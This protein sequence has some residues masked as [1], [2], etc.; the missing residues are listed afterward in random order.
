MNDKYIFETESPRE[1]K[2]VVSRHQLLLT[3]DEINNWRR[4]IY[5]GY[6]SN[7]RIL[8]N[9]KLYTSMEFEEAR[10]KLP[11]DNRG[12]VKDVKYVYLDNDLINKIDDLLYDIKDLLDY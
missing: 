3:L 11:K 2:L 10:D 5:K 8:C 12:L 4:E 9:G 6:D 7:L 1:M